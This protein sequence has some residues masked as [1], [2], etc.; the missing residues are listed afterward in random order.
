MTNND[1]FITT[2]KSNHKSK[3]IYRIYRLRSILHEKYG[4]GNLQSRHFE[5]LFNK[6]HNEDGYELVWINTTWEEG[7][8]RKII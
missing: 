8:F 5:E 2:N 6:I 3:A 1:P 7:V 4:N